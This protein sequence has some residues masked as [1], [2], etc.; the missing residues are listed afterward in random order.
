MLL[1]C[2]SDDGR[3][4]DPEKVRNK[5]KSLG[6]DCTKEDDNQVIQRIFDS[7]VSTKEVV[8]ELVRA[9]GWA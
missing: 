4:V 5:M 1:L 8:T 9:G 3:G 2:I 7:Q 6:V